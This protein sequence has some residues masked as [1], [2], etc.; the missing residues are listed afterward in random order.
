MLLEKKAYLRPKIISMGRGVLNSVPSVVNNPN[1]W[2]G[3]SV[4]VPKGNPGKTWQYVLQ[5]T[6]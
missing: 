6:L 5:P 2:G 4:S 1:T 3:M